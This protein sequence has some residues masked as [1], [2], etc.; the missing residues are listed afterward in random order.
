MWPLLPSAARRLDWRALTAP[1]RRRLGP[2]PH[3]LLPLASG[4][5]DEPQPDDREL[6]ALV[7]GGDRD[8]FDILVRRYM[9]PAR[10]VASRLLR[11]EADAEDAVQDA[12]IRALDRLSL[13]DNSRPFGPWFF[14]L[15]SNVAVNARRARTVRETD[16]EPFDAVSTF[17]RPDQDVERDEITTRFTAALQSLPERQRLIVVLFEVDGFSTVEIAGQLDIAPETVRWH[18]HQARKVLRQLLA[19]LRDET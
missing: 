19:P 3:R 4:P 15:L 14:R 10:I 1:V 12:F 16:P 8:A 18:L 5:A 11:N 6:I 9:R 2:G 7:Q 13:F 17:S